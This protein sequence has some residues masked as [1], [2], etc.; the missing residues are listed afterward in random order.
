MRNDSFYMQFAFSLAQAMEGQTAPNP[1]VGAVVVKDH[2]IVGI[3]AHLQA[4]K[5]HAEVYA[6]Q[7]AGI[8]TQGA[9]LFVTLEPCCHHGKTPPC[10]DLI[11]QSGITRV[12]VA[13]IDPNPLMSGK[14]IDILK[15]HHIIVDRCATSLSL[16]D[17]INRSFRYHIT[18]QI[19]YI[20]IK[21]AMSIDGK[22]A[23][24]TRESKWITNEASRQD[25]HL[26]RHQHSAILVG[27]DTIIYDNPLLTTRLNNAI[28][29]NP[30]R[31]ILDTH[32]RIPIESQVITNR[33]APT[34]I[35]TGQAI[36][37]G[38]K[39]KIENQGINIVS[40]STS[41]IILDELL[42]ILYKKGISS[43][44]V[45]GGAKIWSSFLSAGYFQEIIF[46]MAPLLIGGSKSPSF[47]IE[48]ECKDLLHAVSLQ[49][50]ESI[51]LGED[52][53]KLIYYK[54]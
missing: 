18:H 23:T 38:K 27:I 43:I 11:I 51:R 14:G 29:K 19:P 52:D 30:I 1:I 3:G 40:L 48:K 31:I 44:L 21:I 7:M 15:K 47:Y 53:I 35:V 33:D 45:E 46:Y 50:K 5:A 24:S 26:L 9:T 2:Q 42:P 12:V 22:I 16:D 41:R 10:T 28:G 25:A 32:L 37:V 20:T 54:K 13:Q 8:L 34:I 36:D 6:I 49:L 39:E 17:T 4:G